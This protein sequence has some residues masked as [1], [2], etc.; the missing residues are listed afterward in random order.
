MWV[1]AR[2]AGSSG[3]AMVTASLNRLLLDIRP[4]ELS[5]SENFRS[6][7]ETHERLFVDS[8]AELS[9]DCRDPLR[10]SSET[11]AGTVIAGM[12]PRM[13]RCSRSIT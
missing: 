1:L 5:L 12:R 2:G 9:E 8:N 13:P 11:L 3:V 7:L 6:I 10:E 4:N